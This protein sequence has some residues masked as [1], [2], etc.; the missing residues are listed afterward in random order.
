MAKNK[1]RQTVDEQPASP[2]KANF[3]R[4]YFDTCVLDQWWPRI[5]RDFTGMLA[6]ARSV[7]I[8]CFVPEP[9]LVELEEHWM[10][11]FAEKSRAFSKHVDR[12]RVEISLPTD[13]VALAWYRT[14]VQGLVAGDFIKSIPFTSRTLEYAFR[15]A[16]KKLA[17][18]EEETEFR[19]GIIQMSILEHLSAGKSGPGAILSNDKGFREQCREFSR[20]E[21]VKVELY[22]DVLELR[23]ALETLLSRVTAEK[24]TADKALLAAAL[25]ESVIREYIMRNV[26]LRVSPDVRAI[27]ALQGLSMQRIEAPFPPDRKEN[28]V[29]E[30]SFDLE[31]S[32]L[33]TLVKL[34]YEKPPQ[35][36]SDEPTLRIG[37]S[38]PKQMQTHGNWTGSFVFSTSSP[39]QVEAD[40]VRTFLLRIRARARYAARSYTEISLTGH[41]YVDETSVTSIE[42]IGFENAPVA[43]NSSKLGQVY[44]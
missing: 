15:M 38:N 36:E 10:M 24:V 12:I 21:G 43:F 2:D 19:D 33:V 5:S 6:V 44:T 20:R 7:G 4:V 14:Q 27:K 35:Q 29:I 22:S 42:S 25:Q 3:S 13:D 23:T 37:E 39:K 32:L 40:E 16:A 17:P 9:V 18:F 8:P 28:Q 1:N 34:V 11:E 30:F 31:V 41:E 26:T